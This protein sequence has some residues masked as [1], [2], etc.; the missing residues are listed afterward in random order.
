M[1]FKVGDKV[2][3]KLGDQV[4]EGVI[5]EIDSD[6]EPY[7]VYFDGWNGGHNGNDVCK[8]NYE[9]FHCWWLRDDKLE[10][11]E[12]GEKDM[13]KSDL[14][15]GAI[16]ETREGNKYILLLNTKLYD[17]EKPIL[18]N[19]ANGCYLPYLGY[20]E[21]L[22]HNNKLLDIMKI[23]QHEYVGDNIRNHI[24]KWNENDWTWIRDEEKSKYF[25]GKVVCID[26]RNDFLTKGKIYEFKDGLSIDDENDVFPFSKDRITDI[27]NLNKRMCSEF[28]EI[29]E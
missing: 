27:D 28:I 17:D 25:T 18:V 9:G 11:I 4:R 29:K 6:S 22:T 7:L 14:K 2:R 16:V 24:L 23:C 3:A 20:N 12:R 26:C 10:L 1:K 15:N 13:K 19:L 21:D 8:G 5:K